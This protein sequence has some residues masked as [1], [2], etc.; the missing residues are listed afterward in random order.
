M[1]DLI[2]II[3]P[4]Y[5]GENFLKTC[6]DSVLAQTYENI[7]VILVDDASPD[8]SG[9]ICDAYAIK[10]KRVRVIHFEANEGIS[11][12]R[13]HGIEASS[14]KYL[15]FIDDDDYIAPDMCEILLE[16]LIKENAQISIGGTFWVYPNYIKEEPMQSAY[17]V[18]SGKEAAKQYFLFNGSEGLLPAPWGK[19]FDRRLFGIG[20]KMESSIRFPERSY[21]EDRAIIHCLLYRAKKIVITQKPMYFYVQRVDSTSHAGDWIKFLPSFVQLFANYYK[22]RQDKE[23]E[24]SMAVECRCINSFSN[25]VWEYLKRGSFAKVEGT[26]QDLNDYIVKNT[27]DLNQNLYATSKEKRRLWLMKRHWLIK[28]QQARFWIKR[29]KHRNF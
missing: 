13:N 17:R 29:L 15:M 28:K 22:W 19:L 24:I 20:T 3:I 7:E 6:V 21:N 2:S 5:K 26:L 11:I 8:A 10:D 1:N 18:I 14:G 12:A 25:L 9:E 23:N 27:H 16:N 4:V